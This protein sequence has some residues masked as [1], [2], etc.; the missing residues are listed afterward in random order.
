MKFLADENVKRRL[1]LWLK[2][3]GH[4]VS[5]AP[6]G[7]RNSH[8]F[9]LAHREKCILLTNDTDFLNT[10]MYPPEKTYGR[11]VLR[12]LPPTLENQKTGL[13]ILLAQFKEEQLF[14]GKLIELWNSDFEVRTK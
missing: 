11:I 9:S 4:H 14:F 6:K 1:C 2:T 8:L 3:L 5:T 13:Q 12:I 7:V 10:A